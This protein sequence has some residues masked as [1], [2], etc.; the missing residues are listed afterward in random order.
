MPHN[1]YRTHCKR[2]HS[3]ADAILDRRGYRYCR[4]CRTEQLAAITNT[5]EGIAA[6]LEPQGACLVWTGATC[7]GHGRVAYRGRLWY[8]HRLLWEQANGPVPDGF[9]LDHVCMVKACANLDH[10]RPVDHRTNTTENTNGNASKELCANGH[11][12]DRIE[13]RADGSFRGRRCSQC[14][15]VNARKAYLKRKG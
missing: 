6:R 7:K 9:V 5:I 8:V 13:R 11:P 10:L 15:A 12:Y 3:L 1:R 2:G 14:I 4:I